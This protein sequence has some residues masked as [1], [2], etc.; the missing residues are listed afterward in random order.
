MNPNCREQK[1][2]EIKDLLIKNDSLDLDIILSMLKNEV[3]NQ[4]S[5]ITNNPEKT[6]LEQKIEN[7]LN[8]FLVFVRNLKTEY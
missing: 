2:S 5:S 6:G 4:I 1:L 3:K 8:N 7:D